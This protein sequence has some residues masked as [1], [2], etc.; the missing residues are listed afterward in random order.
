VPLKKCKRW[1]VAPYQQMLRGLLRRPRQ[2][3]WAT[4]NPN[5]PIAWD[6]DNILVCERKKVGRHMRIVASGAIDRPSGALNTAS[7][8]LTN[9]REPRRRAP[10]LLH[11]F[12]AHSR[13]DPVSGVVA[14]S[15]AGFCA[16]LTQG[17]NP[18]RRFPCFLSQTPCLATHQLLRGRGQGCS[19]LIEA[20]R[21]RGSDEIGIAGIHHVEL[22]HVILIPFSGEHPKAVSPL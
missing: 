2:I 4:V 13:A 8:S 5:I 19:L 10:G 22:I 17:R 16:S 3:I 20:R 15:L 1:D 9:T 6:A 12:S 7:E 21:G 18:T 11:C 14:R